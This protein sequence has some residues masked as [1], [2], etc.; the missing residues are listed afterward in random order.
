MRL[1]F[2]GR[3]GSPDDRPWRRKIRF[4]EN[5]F[6]SALNR[7]YPNGETIAAE[8]VQA[9]YWSLR[10]ASLRLPKEKKYETKVC[11]KCFGSFCR[12]MLSLFFMM[13]LPICEPCNWI[14]SSSNCRNLRQAKNLKDTS[15]SAVPTPI[16]STLTG[17]SCFFVPLLHFTQD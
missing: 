6:C 12:G 17:L 8:R 10:L 11:S 5:R 1:G 3:Y 9:V 2:L 16:L 13:K 4:L 7:S 15:S 14:M